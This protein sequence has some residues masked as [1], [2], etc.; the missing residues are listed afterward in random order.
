[1]D[2]FR[3]VVIFYIELKLTVVHILTGLLSE[4]KNRG[5]WLKDMRKWFFTIDE[6]L[7]F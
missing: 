3:L 4:I 1:M 2:L 6:R 7:M 5:Q